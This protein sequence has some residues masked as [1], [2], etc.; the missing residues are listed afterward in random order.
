VVCGDAIAISFPIHNTRTKKRTVRCGGGS[1]SRR[2]LEDNNTVSEISCHYEI[3]LDNESRLLRMQDE[4]LDHLRCN[5]SLLRI[6]E[7][8]FSLSSRELDHDVRIRTKR[9]R[10]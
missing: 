4:P 7:T 9:A 5:D 3:V 1:D 10:R 2:A 8:G 6:Q